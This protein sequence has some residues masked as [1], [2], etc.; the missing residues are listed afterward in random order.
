MSIEMV[1]WVTTYLLIILAELGDKTQVAILLVTSNNPNHRWI[2]FAASCVALALCVS[3]EVTIGSTLAHYIGVNVINRISGA[4]F[5]VIGVIGLFKNDRAGSGI[6][7]AKG[8]NSY[9]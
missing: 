8:Q 6:T 9:N 4:I 7:I 5:L 2:V 1:T 3:I